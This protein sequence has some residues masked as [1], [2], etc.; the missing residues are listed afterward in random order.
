MKKKEKN[1]EKKTTFINNWLVNK[2]KSFKVAKPRTTPQII[3]MFFKDYDIKNS[4][5]QLDDNH[6]L[7]C[8]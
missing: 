5:I 1:K 8:F 6:F 3:R 7:L 4:I 2:T